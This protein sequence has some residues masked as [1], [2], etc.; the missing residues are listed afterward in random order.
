[1][2]PTEACEDR[3]A[4]VGILLVTGKDNRV[5]EEDNIRHVE[6]EA[7]YVIKV[8]PMQDRIRPKM[9]NRHHEKKMGFAA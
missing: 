3:H 1:M 2:L 5:T 9:H 4:L 6:M 7:C 8:V